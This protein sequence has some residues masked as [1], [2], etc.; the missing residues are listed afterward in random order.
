MNKPEVIDRP[1]TV[2]PV[3]ATVPVEVPGGAT[4]MLLNNPVTPFEVVLEALMSATGL[5]HAEA[6]KRM[7]KCHQN[8][9]H[10]VASY[11]SVDVAQTVAD[12]ITRHAA[13]NG[14]Y[15]RYRPLVKHMGPWPLDTEVMDAGQ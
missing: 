14:R 7:M 15:E 4:V 6:Y 8:G 9:W 12:K 13:A 3:E 1:P 5:S 2:T 10:P 11:G